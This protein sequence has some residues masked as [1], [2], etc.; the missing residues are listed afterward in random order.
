MCFCFPNVSLSFTL[1]F[2]LRSAFEATAF[3]NA[4]SRN[5]ADIYGFLPRSK[6]CRH[7]PVSGFL[8]N[9]ILRYLSFSFLSSLVLRYLYCLS[10]PPYQVL[11]SAVQKLVANAKCRNISNYHRYHVKLLDFINV[12]V[13][14]KNLVGY[15]EFYSLNLVYLVIIQ[16]FNYAPPPTWKQ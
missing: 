12:Y 4:F 9:S 11:I 16:L 14:N 7:F 5:A 8:S 2:P 6:R 13:K 10:Y 1:L 15:I 3:S